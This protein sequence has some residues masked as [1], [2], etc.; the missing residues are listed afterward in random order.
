MNV[1]KCPMCQGDEFYDGT[2]GSATHVSV[3]LGF[4]SNAP[5]KCK[6]CLACGFV[7]TFVIHGGLVAIRQ[8]ARWPWGKS[9]VEEVKEEIRE[10]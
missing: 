5:V 1:K 3:S 7:A 8:K 2:F 6:V 4:F 10:L 9:R